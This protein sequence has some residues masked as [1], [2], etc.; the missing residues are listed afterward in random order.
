MHVISCFY[1]IMEWFPTAFRKIVLEIF[2][3]N[4][5]FTQIEPILCEKRK[6][7]KNVENNFAKTA[8]NHPIMRYKH[9]IK[10]IGKLYG[11]IFRILIFFQKYGFF[12][13]PGPMWSMCRILEL[14]TKHSQNWSW[15]VL[16][17][18]GRLIWKLLKICF[19]KNKN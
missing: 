19:C 16:L 12:L 10:C 7:S 1:R 13:H 14:R 18:L 11:W 9:E 8:G 3:K 4:V 15:A 2:C 6:F 5:I 17:P